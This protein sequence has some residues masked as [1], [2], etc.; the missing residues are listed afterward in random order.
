LEFYREIRQLYRPSENVIKHPVITGGRGIPITGHHE[1]LI[2]L[3][4]AWLV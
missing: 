4:A 2:S 3:L 1:I